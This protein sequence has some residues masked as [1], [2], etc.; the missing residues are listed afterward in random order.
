MERFDFHTHSTASDGSLPPARVVAE[1][2]AAGVTAFALTDH[3]TVG[4]IA[5]AQ[6]EGRRLGIEVIPGI[7]LSVSERDGA[8]S[9]HVLGL[10]LDPDEPRLR[11]RLAE[12]GE[13]RARRAERIVAALQE[14]GIGLELAH[15][16]RLAGAGA[17]GRPHVAR[18]LVEIGACRDVD[19]A[20]ARWLRRG[21]P[22]YVPNAAFGAR[23]AIECVHGAGGVAV[24]AH[25]PLSSGVD[26]PGG[27]EAFVESLVP[28]G[29]D[30]V[31]V[32]HPN[33]RPGTVRRLRQI[34]RRFGL[35][36]SGGSDFHGED[37]PEV[38]L[39]RGRANGLKVG[40]DVYEA[41]AD[42]AK[43]RRTAY[44]AVPR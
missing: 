15:V 5:E 27:L 28:L 9:L 32:W 2:A 23:E 24:L 33:H 10:W 18:A 21:K 7:E 1:A 25:P 14:V 20:F 30:G 8:R 12:A 13:A 4:G 38:K 16:Q 6:A 19:E 41:L 34:A 35:I 43:S 37:R 29:L 31:E 3:D 17:V 39:G 36:E 42:R 26:A 44:P 22:A 40:R 11:A